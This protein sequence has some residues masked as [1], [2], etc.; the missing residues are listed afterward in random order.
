MITLSTTHLS[1]IQN[2]AQEVY[3]DECV[4]ALLGDLAYATLTKTVYETVRL[5]NQWDD[6]DTETK[7]RRFKVT[8]FDYQHVE[9]LAQ[10]KGMDLLGFY[11]SHPDHP[12]IPS[13]TDL[14]YAWPVFSYLIL[15][16]HQGKPGDCLSYLLSDEGE[17][18]AEKLSI[19]AS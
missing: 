7:R 15:P 3:P 12:A 9:S 1:E 11:H 17:F 16:I 2:H 19:L 13:E 10:E 14:K 6:S 18:I 5:D 8:A 4:G